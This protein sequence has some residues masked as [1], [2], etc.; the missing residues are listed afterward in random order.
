MRYRL[1]F[2]GIN[3]ALMCGT[4][5]AALATVTVGR[6]AEKE[7]R[8]GRRE[9]EGEGKRERAKEETRL[10]RSL[11]ILCVSLHR[12]GRATTL[13]CRIRAKERK[14]KEHEKGGR[15]ERD[16]GGGERGRGGGGGE[17]EGGEGRA[18]SA[19]INSTYKSCPVTP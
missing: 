6:P 9:K 12:R 13:V 10:W 2:R 1:G 8:N 19:T 3:L 15:R 5:N 4:S 11:G 14:W 7:T 18:D 17:G 16:G